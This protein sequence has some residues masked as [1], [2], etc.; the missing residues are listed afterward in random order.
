MK[1]IAILTFVLT[2]ILCNMNVMADEGTYPL[3]VTFPASGYN[4]I[5]VVTTVISTNDYKSVTVELQNDL[6]STL[7]LKINDN[8]ATSQDNFFDANSGTKTLTVSLTDYANAKGTTEVDNVILLSC[9]PS[10]DVSYVIK[11]AY[12]T[13]NDGST[14]KMVCTN[15]NATAFTWSI[16][17]TQLALLG[18]TSTDLTNLGMGNIVIAYTTEFQP[19]GFTDVAGQPNLGSAYTGYSFTFKPSSVGAYRVRTNDE[20]AST[21]TENWC[22]NPSGTVTGTLSGTITHFWLQ[23]MWATTESKAASENTPRYVYVKDAYFTKSDGTQVEMI[24]YGKNEMNKSDTYT[25]YCGWYPF[26]GKGTLAYGDMSFKYDSLD[27]TGYSYIGI[28]FAT[29]TPMELTL[30]FWLDDTGNNISTVTIPAGTVGLYQ[31]AIPAKSNHIFPTVDLLN[32]S[33]VSGSVS[34]SNVSLTVNKTVTGI[35]PLISDGSKVK[36]D[37]IYNLNGQRVGK[38]YKGFVIKNG[39]KYIAK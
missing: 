6:T 31:A 15:M 29:A 9:A 24:P 30:Q 34:I 14:E 25:N 12:L 1:R 37:A 18:N 28:T 2:V 20:D 26:A 10:S 16:S 17:D 36:N 27:V 33:N 19:F 22:N 39:K 8:K 32:M 3:T 7:D 11:N 13:K 35:N 4:A 5:N 21:A 38:D 23:R